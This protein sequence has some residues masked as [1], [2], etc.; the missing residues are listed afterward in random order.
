M[1]GYS[2]RL[3][4]ALV[5]LLISSSA[6]GQEYFNVATGDW[7]TASNWSTA[8]L[9]DGTQPQTFI[10]AMAGGQQTATAEITGTLTNPSVG[11]LRIGSSDDGAMTGGEP[12]GA[13]G[14][15]NHSDGT[16]SA[17]AWSFI[18]HYGAMSGA[19]LGTYNLSG[20]ATLNSGAVLAIGVAGDGRNT[21]V[22]NVSD[23]A[24]LNT[25]TADG[26]LAV[27][28]D[29]GNSG[30]L[31]QTGGTINNS[32]ATV[33]VHNPGTTGEYNFSGGVFNSTAGLT[34]GE[35][36]GAVGVTNVS[37]T[38][39]M[40]VGNLFVGRNDGSTGTLNI[41]GS[42]ATVDSAGV[43][44]VGISD[45]GVDTTAIGTLSFTADSSGITTLNVAGTVGLSPDG[46]NLV[47]DMSAHPSFTCGTVCDEI[48]L[49]SNGSAAAVGGMF[50]S[51][52]EGAS[53]A[54]SGGRVITYLGG[55]GNDISLV[56]PVPEPSS[57]LMIFV[58]IAVLALRRR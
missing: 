56:A 24:V 45:A 30:I 33:A 42:T 20:T 6:F 31:N 16:L 22:M 51:L 40:N 47:V 54:G 8:A 43:L 50:D 26:G 27:G 17:A 41:V 14:T 2:L 4:L 11:E 49:I 18:G 5:G 7:D 29:L 57:F 58:G 28:W 39:D 53:V 52:A 36:D 1:R 55:D 9:P 35:N 10:G 46:A 12:G 38:A 19:N 15:V 3:F 48:I 13:T 25:N 21:G 44:N 32:W 34:I 37:G 23:N